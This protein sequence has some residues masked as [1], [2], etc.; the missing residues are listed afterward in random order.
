MDS[1]DSDICLE[2]KM[3]SRGFELVGFG[4]HREFNYLII[5]LIDIV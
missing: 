1:L 2:T 4:V 3:G 5:S